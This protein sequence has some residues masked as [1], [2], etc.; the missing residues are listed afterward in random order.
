MGCASE[1]LAVLCIAGPSALATVM[2]LATRE[3]S[4]LGMWAVAITVTSDPPRFTSAAPSGT[5]VSASGT[6]PVTR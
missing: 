3:P 2:L 5:T 1:R 6:S 4:K